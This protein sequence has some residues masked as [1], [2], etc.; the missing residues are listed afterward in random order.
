MDRLNKA[1]WSY[2]CMFLWN[3]IPGLFA[4]RCY[5]TGT[6]GPSR[7]G[8]F[9]MS[10]FAENHASSWLHCFHEIPRCLECRCL[11]SYILRCLF[12]CLRGSEFMKDFIFFVVWWRIQMKFETEKLL[13]SVL[14]RWGND[15]AW[16]IDVCS[17]I[18]WDVRVTFILPVSGL[19]LP[20]SC[21]TVDSHKVCNEYW[22]L[23]P[24]NG[25][26]VVK[27]KATLLLELSSRQSV[28]MFRLLC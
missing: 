17:L 8:M 3:W 16:V 26:Y 2:T 6:A 11:I 18:D 15:M 4:R 23:R 9:L 20:Y 28:V 12:S 27:V 10:T 24:R 5:W 1:I 25:I 13:C 19:T 22:D 7:L 21:R 14:T